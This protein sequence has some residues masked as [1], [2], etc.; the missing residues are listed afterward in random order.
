MHKGYLVLQNGRVFSG[1]RFGAPGE[2]RAELVFA[3][4]MVGYIETLTDPS[5]HGQ[6]VAFTFPLIGNYGVIPEDFEGAPARLSACIVREAALT[7]SNFRSQARLHEY[8]AE[9]GVVAL[10]GID[11]RALTK[12]L[13]EEGEM[14]AA[15]L[16]S[17]PSDMEA[18]TREL[19][20]FSIR[21][22]VYAVTCPAPYALGETGRHAVLW[23][24]GLKRTMVRALTERGL[25]VTVMPANSSADDILR[26]APDGVLLSGGPGDPAAHPEILRE[27]ARVSEARVPLMGV[28]LGH[29]MLSL[30]RGAKCIRLKYGHRGGNQPVR[31]KADGRLFTT[32]QN[33]SYA[34]SSEG[35]PEGASISYENVNDRTCEGLDYRDIPAFSVQFHPEAPAGPLNTSSLFDRFIGM[36]GGRAHAAV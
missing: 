3:T 32:S 19:A 15:I 22:D 23:D 13:R 7:P 24:F 27:I 10:Q 17:L 4:G 20:A 9:S 28:C 16:D 33:H 6:M 25:R 34:V 31:R 18:F 36:M 35:L 30:A 1:E 26:L 2:A 14:N 11:T 29:Q 8:L 21:A 12:L 5:Y